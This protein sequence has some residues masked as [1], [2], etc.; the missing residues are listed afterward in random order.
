M[1]LDPG[2]SYAE[3]YKKSLNQ[4]GPCR[5]SALTLNVMLHLH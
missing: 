3:K 4:K 1:G 2:F 5:I